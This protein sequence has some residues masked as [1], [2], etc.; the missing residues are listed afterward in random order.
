MSVFFRNNRRFLILGKTLYEPFAEFV[1]YDVEEEYMADTSSYVLVICL[2]TVSAFVLY[3]YIKRIRTKEK[4]KA[5][6][7]AALFTA[8]I[9][10][11]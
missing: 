9:Y 6:Y 1:G 2:L 11:F 10:R 7:N 3:R 5:L 8:S 4:L